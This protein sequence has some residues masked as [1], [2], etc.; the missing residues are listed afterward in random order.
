MATERFT[1]ENTL[2]ILLLANELAPQVAEVRMKAA[3]VL[4][5]QKK[6]A[7][8]E[9][10]V[11]PLASDPHNARLAAAAQR[12]LAAARAKGAAPAEA[13]ADA[14]GEPAGE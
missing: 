9:S 1:S 13:E 10:M 4:L 6:F 7:E 5:A 11:L 12:L 14:G 8:A 2:N 3:S